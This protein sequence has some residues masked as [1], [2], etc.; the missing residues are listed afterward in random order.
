MKKITLTLVAL[1]VTLCC[2]FGLVA[3]GN[4]DNLD[5]EWDVVNYSAQI[6]GKTYYY[7]DGG[8]A[9]IDGKTN[10]L[11]TINAK[12]VEKATCPYFGTIVQAG[13]NTTNFRAEKGKS[14]L[15]WSYDGDGKDDFLKIGMSNFNDDV[16]GKTPLKGVLLRKHKEDVK[17]YYKFGEITEGTVFGEYT[18]H[19]VEV[20]E[21]MFTGGFVKNGEEYV[22]VG[23]FMAGAGCYSVVYYKATDMKATRDVQLL[24]ADANGADYCV[25]SNSMGGRIIGARETVAK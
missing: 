18:L 8:T 20:Y 3:C 11:V 15:G 16:V 14:V 5:G 24:K 2:A 7:D 19:A 21:D 12:S 25:E 1:V 13:T 9:T 10:N 17:D 6:D 23:K 22:A 4:D